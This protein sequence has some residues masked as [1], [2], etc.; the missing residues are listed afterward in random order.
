MFIKGT[1]ISLLN[2]LKIAFCKHNK[3]VSL[4]DYQDR[5]V[6]YNCKKC[7]KVFYEDI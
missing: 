6:K 3:S 1:R 7:G 4:I 2:M 5:F